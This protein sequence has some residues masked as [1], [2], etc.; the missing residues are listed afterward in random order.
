MDTAL[1]GASGYG[2]GSGGGGV[3]GQARIGAV[4][5]AL[6]ITLVTVSALSGAVLALL[7]P[8]E[9]MLDGSPAPPPLEWFRPR[10]QGPG[11]RK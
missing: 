11:G 8:S 1:L 5:G 9:Q 6:V 10:W 2:S 7:A 3:A 4:P